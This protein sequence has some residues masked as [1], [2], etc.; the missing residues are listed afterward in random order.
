MPTYT[1]GDSYEQIPVPSFTKPT[2]T[3]GSTFGDEFH[4]PVVF[5]LMASTKGGWT[6]RG[7]VLAGGAGVIPT[8]TVLAQYTSGPNQYLYGVYS[9][10][11]SNGLNAPLGFLR[12]GTDTGGASSPS[13]LPSA[14]TSGLLVTSGIVNYTVTSGLD[15]GAI[16]ALVGR[17][18]PA[19]N[20]FFF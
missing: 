13:G 15:S 20:E 7:V 17:L 6:Q 8:G 1:P 19:V 12:N 14:N 3:Y 2:H 18:D 9:S 16:T 10:G 11:G 5:E 4:A